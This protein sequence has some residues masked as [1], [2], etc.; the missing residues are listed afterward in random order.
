MVDVVVGHR[1]DPYRSGVARFNQ[2]LATRLRVPVVSFTDP[3]LLRFANPLFSLKP[4]DCSHTEA[5]LLDEVLSALDGRRISTYLHEYLDLP[6]ER[7]LVDASTTTYC[8]NAQIE[9]DVSR[10]AARTMLSWAPSTIERHAPFPKV[11]VSVF[12]FGMAHKVQTRW[13]SRLRT[14]LEASNQSYSLYVSHAHH[15]AA[16]QSEEEVV[17]REMA[18]IFPQHMY[19]LGNLSDVAI[20]N[21]MRTATFFASFF[22]GGVRANNTT[23]RTA[24][25]HEAVVVTNLDQYSPIEFRH[26]SSLVDI[27]Q[28]GALPL[29]PRVLTDI[30]ARGADA[31]RERSWEQLVVQLTDRTAVLPTA[32]G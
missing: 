20:S 30:G 7:H 1:L 6:A 14:L 32:G 5:A 23:I 3:A 15:E 19:F 28:C 10:R 26:M 8:G 4:S 27:A 22:P 24:L 18:S 21:M 13:F 29:D 11:D 16:T 25:E 9:A 2:M 17:F 12:S 31:V